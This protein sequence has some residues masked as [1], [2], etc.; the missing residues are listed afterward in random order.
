MRRYDARSQ[1]LLNTLQEESPTKQ[2]RK[3]AFMDEQFAIY[4]SL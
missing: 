2:E 1:W 4:V 3:D